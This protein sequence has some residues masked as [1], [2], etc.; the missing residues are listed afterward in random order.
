MDL[1]MTLKINN[2]TEV[3]ME[4]VMVN[5]QLTL[6]LADFYQGV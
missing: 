4:T 3:T 2:L 5:N 1:T 6:I